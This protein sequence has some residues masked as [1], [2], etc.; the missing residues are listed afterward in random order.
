[1]KTGLRAGVMRRQHSFALAVAFVILSGA[2]QAQTAA[3]PP[4]SSAN[5]TRLRILTQTTGVDDPFP[6]PLAQ[7]FGLGTTAIK[8][9]QLAAVSLGRD[10]YLVFLDLPSSDVVLTVKETT[11]ISIYLTDATRTLRNAAEIDAAGTRVVNGELVVKG[12]AEALQ[13][14]NELA[15]MQDAV[16]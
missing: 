6:A 14:W 5:L 7:L 4:L 8:A 3:A 10:F 11:R 12:F 9:K 2:L 16:K 15:V 1:M 13:R